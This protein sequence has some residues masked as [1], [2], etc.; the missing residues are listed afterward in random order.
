MQ[1]YQNYASI[2]GIFVN[3]EC[4]FRKLLHILFWITYYKVKVK[5]KVRKKGR[6]YV[7]TSASLLICQQIN[8]LVLPSRNKKFKKEKKMRKN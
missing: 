7:H 4:G 1:I 8:K 6:D 2:L 3:V 5:K